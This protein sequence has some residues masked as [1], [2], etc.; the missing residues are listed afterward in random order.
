MFFKNNIF[1]LYYE[2]YGKGN[3]Y[4]LILPGWGDNRNTF[5]NI[6]NYFKD[7]YHIFIFDYPGFGMS[8]FPNKDL[9]IYQ[10][11][12]VFYKFIKEKKIKNPI[13]IAHSFGGRI[14][15]LL[16]TYNNIKIS[17]MIFI[18]TAGIKEKKSLKRLFKEKIYKILK[19]ICSFS[20]N[21]DLYIKKL[22]KRFGSSDFNRL[23]KK[24]HKTFINIVNEDLTSY[25]KLIKAEVLIIWGEYDNITTLK[26]GHLFN[27]YIK[28][29]ALIV[30]EKANHF[31]YLEKPYLTN[32]IIYNFIK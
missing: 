26:Y 6:I 21:K 8:I 30:Y 31:S 10:Y 27:K 15:T 4:L 29:S 9:T 24:M 7:K 1:D 19:K 32:D 5:T 23:D 14:A 20:K 17:K 18:D 13:I 11:S 2:E 22:Q 12:E 25:I 16:N 3:N 28:N